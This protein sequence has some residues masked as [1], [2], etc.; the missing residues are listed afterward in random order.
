MVTVCEPHDE[1]IVTEPLCFLTLI[2]NVVEPVPVT[3]AESGET[4]IWP[5]LLDVAVIVPLPLKLFR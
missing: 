5:L 1:E 3:V 2:V 4:C